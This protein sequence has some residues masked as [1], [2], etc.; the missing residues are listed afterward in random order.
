MSDL[1]S[2]DSD[3]IIVA[4]DGVKL[5]FPKILLS[6]ASTVFSD[7]FS[8]AQPNSSQDSD[9]PNDPINLPESSKTIRLMISLANSPHTSL[10]I[11][12]LSDFANLLQA[13]DKYDIK[14]IQEHAIYS[15]RQPRFLENEPLRVYAIASRYH[16]ILLCLL[17]KIPFGIRSCMHRIFPSWRLLMVGLSP[18]AGDVA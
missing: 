7:M 11:E 6:Q 13:A 5:S 15:L 3:V 8:V 12:S 9:G 18:L 2:R 4:S 16:T 17:L 1:N 14:N 10:L